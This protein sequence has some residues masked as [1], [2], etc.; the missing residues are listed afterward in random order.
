MKSLL[1]DSSTHKRYAA[2]IA[3]GLGQ[4][5]VTYLVLIVLAT[6][7]YRRVD[8]ALICILGAGLT[9]AVVF[10]LLL[11]GPVWF[12]PVGFLVV[13]ALTPYI[14]MMVWG[15]LSQHTFVQLDPL[16]TVFT[17]L[18]TACSLP[19]AILTAIVYLTVYLLSRNRRGT[20]Q[21]NTSALM[22]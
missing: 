6:D 7:T 16:A 11:K 22:Q 5:L 4:G 15:L 17:L 10:G 1:I 21:G 13:G 8:N 3:W 9:S 18:W 20:A 12:Q 2:S 14:V 19:F